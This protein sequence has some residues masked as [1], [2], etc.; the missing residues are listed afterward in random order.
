MEHQQEIIEAF[1][2]IAKEKKIEKE[3]L[4]DIFE[5]VILMM[6]KKKYGSTDN[7][8]VIVNMEKGE[9]EIYQE[10]TIVEKIEDQ[11]TEIDLKSAQKIEP[12]VELGEI[13]VEVIGPFSF[14]R[15]LITTAKQNLIQRIRDAEKE[16]IINE[17]QNRI[18]EII[19]GDIHQIKRDRV[20]IHLDNTTEVVMTREEQIPTERY[21][22]NESVRAVIKS[23]EVTNH[24]P[25]IIVSRA[26][27]DFLIRLFEL[28]VPEIYDGI[29]EIKDIARDAG[30]RTKISVYSNDKRI[31]AVGACVGMKGIRIQ[32]VV[33]E[34]NNEKIDV[35]N[36][37]SEPEI[38]ISRALSPAKPIQ[39]ILDKQNKIANAIIPDDQVSQAIG[40]DGKNLRLA[41]QLTGYEIEPI[42]ESDA[43]S[44]DEYLENIEALTAKFIEK[45]EEAGLE[46]AQ[47]VLDLGVGGLMG[48][49]G[50]GP[51]SAEKILKIIETY[52]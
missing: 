44:T 5:N 51:K 1:S 10:K 23:V 48:I 33:R 36:W 52:V 41:S 12:D 28:E 6:I 38:Y 35:I 39:I 32:A 25:E 42:K 46:T 8:D 13:F 24:G 20:F 50:I 26:A 27:P 49:K 17:F 43:Y 40:R 7:F 18:G 4:N 15:R 14:G 29:I 3:A 34:L 19:I 45:L 22:R 21:R 37:T 2:E 47:Q 31:D 11:Q 30:E 16:R 9:I